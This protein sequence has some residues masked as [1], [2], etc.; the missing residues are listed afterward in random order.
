V[1]KKKDQRV[2]LV[3]LHAEKCRKSKFDARPDLPARQK[4]L[5]G[6]DLS[7]ESL[8][9]IVV[10]DADLAQAN[11]ARAK[12]SEAE[13][14]EC[15]LRQAN[16]TSADLT[17]CNFFGSDLSGSDFT[18]AS[19]TLARFENCVLNGIKGMIIFP[20]SEQKVSTKGK[21]IVQAESDKRLTIK[22]AFFSL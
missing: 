14:V 9:Q 7:D 6:I 22:K 12:L 4:M 10:H 19:I 17:E 1:K 18:D 21:L 3:R 2:P 20:K 13:L 5:R 11:F 8:S 16:F 15:D